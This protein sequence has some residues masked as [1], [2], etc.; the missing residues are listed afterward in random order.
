MKAGLPFCHRQQDV[1]AGL[2]QEAACFQALRTNK[3]VPHAGRH[4][5]RVLAR[6]P[7]PSVLTCLMAMKASL[8]AA[9]R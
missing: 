1:I 9:S 3:V 7:T 5:L 8:L 6:L 4:H 2:C